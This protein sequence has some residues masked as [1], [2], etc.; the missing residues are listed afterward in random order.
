M[1]R[2]KENDKENEDKNMKSGQER[3]HNEQNR[4]KLEGKMKKELGNQIQMQNG[5][6]EH[7]GTDERMTRDKTMRSVRK[8]TLYKMRGIA[9]SSN[10]SRGGEFQKRS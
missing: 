5:K 1:K 4:S 3:I 2:K 6:Q 8:T 7:K 9:K 10:G